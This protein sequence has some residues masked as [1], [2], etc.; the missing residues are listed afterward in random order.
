MIAL[1]ELKA[2]GE[3]RHR[4]GKFAINLSKNLPTGPNRHPPR[5][6]EPAESGRQRQS[7]LADLR[8]Y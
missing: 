6:E 2:G 8:T 7:A 1:Q 3:R 4:T 5:P